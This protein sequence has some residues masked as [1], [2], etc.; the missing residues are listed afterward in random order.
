MSPLTFSIVTPS[1]N[2]GEFLAQTIESVLGQRGDFRIDY[3]IMDGGSRDGSV[4]IIRKYEGLLQRGEWPVA[5]A[6]IRFRW[7]SGKDA[8]QADAIMKGFAKAEGEILAWLNSDDTYLPDALKA[9]ALCFEKEPDLALL[10]GDAYYCDSAGA[11]VGKY[12]TDD[13]DLD[14]LAYYNI[15]CQPS[16]FFRRGA[17]EAAGGL[18]RSLSYAMDFDL[19]IRLGKGFSCRH[20]AQFLSVYRLHESSKTVREETLFENSEE[21][22]RLTLKYFDWAPLTR[23]YNSCNFYCRSHLPHVLDRQGAAV[24]MATLACTILRSL[25]LNRGIRKRDLALLNRENFA[26]LRKSRLEIMTETKA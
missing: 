13:F 19:W 26:K 1:Y 9:A 16:A 12:R 4:E 24:T 8:G 17:F 6:G 5:C 20:L 11:V 7:T 14:R 2:Q 10:Y 3:L 23:V 22:L 15:I 25:W 21:A 18:D